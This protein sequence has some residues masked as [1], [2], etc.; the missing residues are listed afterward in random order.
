MLKPTS[1]GEQ[2]HGRVIAVLYIGFAQSKT[3]IQSYWHD[4]VSSSTPK[5]NIIIIKHYV[6]AYEHTLVIC[7]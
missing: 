5:Y 4:P 2:Q 1:S 6:D 3:P 7:P